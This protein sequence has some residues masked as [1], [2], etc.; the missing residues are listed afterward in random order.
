MFDSRTHMSDVV[1]L[2]VSISSDPY[3]LTSP[4]TTPGYLIVATAPSPL[5][6]CYAAKSNSSK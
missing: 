1:T 6:F 3:I 4:S 5:G 2:L